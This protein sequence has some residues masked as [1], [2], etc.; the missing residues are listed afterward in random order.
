MR[1][2]WRHGMAGW[3][4]AVRRTGLD[5]LAYFQQ[6]YPDRVEDQAVG[7]IA[8]LQVGAD[9]VDRRPDVGHPLPFSPG[10]HGAAA[11]GT[12]ARAAPPPLPAFRRSHFPDPPPASLRRPLAST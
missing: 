8:A 6:P 7:Q 3:C 5:R 10:G 4:R 11:A 2:T 9:R 1:V 12:P